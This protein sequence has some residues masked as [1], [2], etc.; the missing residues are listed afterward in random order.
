[1]TEGPFGFLPL[2]DEQ[3]AALKQ[4]YEHD[5]MHIQDNTHSVKHL[6]NELSKDNLEAL[7]LVL[8]QCFHHINIGYFRGQ[9]TQILEKKYNV[10]PCGEDHDLQAAEPIGEP[11]L[12]EVD[13][14][15]KE[16]SLKWYNLCEEYGV[17]AEPYSD[18]DGYVLK[19]T[20]CGAAVSSLDDRMLKPPGPAG[21][22][23]CQDKM[24]W[25]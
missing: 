8:L 9:I 19:C 10:C 16:G 1:M 2:N 4:R 5:Q 22:A 12:T 24:K 20:G 13:D 3:M 25:G 7:D 18:A 11:V 21:C 14:L 15:V 6:L 17:I 23:T